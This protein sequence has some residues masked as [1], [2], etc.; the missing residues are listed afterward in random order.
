MVTTSSLELPRVTLPSVDKD[1]D[2]LAAPPKTDFA[3]SDPDTKK[4][5][6]E[7]AMGKAACGALPITTLPVIPI[8]EL[9]L[10]DPD[11]LLVISAT[12]SLSSY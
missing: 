7:P 8:F 4:T 11:M 1:P 3:V 12:G 5:A 6:S 2:I 10:S 9:L